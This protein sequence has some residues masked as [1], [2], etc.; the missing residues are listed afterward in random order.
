ME[1]TDDMTL[2]AARA[3]RAKLMEISPSDHWPPIE[4]KVD[5]EEIAVARAALEAAL[6]PSP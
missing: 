5:P 6:N 3:I 4:E 1:I 2:K